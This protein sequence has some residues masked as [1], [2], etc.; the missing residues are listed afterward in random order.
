MNRNKL[1]TW[2]GD[3]RQLPFINDRQDI[4]LSGIKGIKEEALQKALDLYD[5]YT[6]VK[7]CTN[8]MKQDVNHKLWLP[9]EIWDVIA[10]LIKDDI[11]R[12]NIYHPHYNLFIEDDQLTLSW[13][14]KYK[15]DNTTKLLNKKDDKE[16]DKE[17]DKL[18]I[19]QT[20][21]YVVVPL[22]ICF[23]GVVIGLYKKL[24]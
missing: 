2:I 7:L 9:I 4:Y 3:D 16:D 21:Y 17:D 14:E 18:Q 22:M 19:Q 15:R 11:E 12:I 24:N 13:L 23:V 20:Y 6:M 1:I 5:R 8:R 10:N